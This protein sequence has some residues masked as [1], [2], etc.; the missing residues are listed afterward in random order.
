MPATGDIPTAITGMIHASQLAIPEGGSHPNFTLKNSISSNA[1]KNAG[2]EANRRDPKVTTRS[3]GE[4]CRVAEM[5]PLGMPRINASAMPRK[6]SFR[7][8]PKR[9]A[10]IMDTLRPEE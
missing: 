5:M 8:V 6:P 7:V 1:E 2:T 4:Y 9:S 3:M 10:I